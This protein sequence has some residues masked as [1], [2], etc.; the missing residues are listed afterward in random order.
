MLQPFTLAGE[1]NS[2]RRT[3]LKSSL[4]VGACAALPGLAHALAAVARP[5]PIG[6]QLFTVRAQLPKDYEGT[7]AKI[8]AIGYQ[9]V[10]AAGFFGHTAKSVKQIMA[11]V[12][13]RCV[14]AHYKLPDLLKSEAQ[15]LEYAQTLGLRYVVCST[16][17]SAHPARLAHYPGGIWAGIARAMTMDDWK[18]TAEQLQRLGERFHEAGLQFAYHTH[19]MAFAKHGDT[20]GFAVLMDGTTTEMVALELDCGWAVAAGQSPVE[21]LQKYPKRIQMLH[22]KDMKPVRPGTPPWGYVPTELGRGTID[23]APILQAAR[24]TA[25]KHVFVEQDDLDVPVWE[26]LKIDYRVM[27]KIDRA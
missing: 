1:M 17:W 20:D 25:V 3:F 24:K 21:L 2:T 6:L 23:Y 8:A 22:V 10:E 7:L 11:R 27:A 14:S 5:Y 26:A 13:L 16:P 4:A 9:E 18:W 12:G 15:I 19:F